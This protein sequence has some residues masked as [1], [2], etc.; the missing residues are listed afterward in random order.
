MCWNSS[1]LLSTFNSQDLSS[2]TQSAGNRSLVTSSSETTRETSNFDFTNFFKFY[3]KLGSQGPVTDN[4]LA[5]F[6]GFAEG[7]GAI[8][9]SKGRPRFVLTQKDEEILLDIQR[10]FNFGAVRSV[11]GKY[12]RFV[13]EDLKHTLLLCLL[14][15]G[16]L[17]LSH[18]KSQLRA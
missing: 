17:I 4:W 14:F 9:T 5:W 15:N 8:L 7:D 6:V 12:Y 2:E 1:I 18:R 3:E 10:T 11:Q 13:V 16:N